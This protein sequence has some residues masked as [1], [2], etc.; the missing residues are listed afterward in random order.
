[1]NKDLGTR[2][3]LGRLLINK[4][5]AMN[6][7]IGLYLITVFFIPILHA[8][9]GVDL[10]APLF[11]W[12]GEWDG[13]VTRVEFMN[14][15]DEERPN[16]YALIRSVVK[17][18]ED[19][20][21]IIMTN[22][23]YVDGRFDVYVSTTFYSPEKQE[24]H[25]LGQYGTGVTT[26]P[27]KNLERNLTNYFN[28]SYTQVS[29]NTWI[30][31]DSLEGHGSFYEEEELVY[32]SWSLAVRVN[33]ENIVPLPNDYT[34]LGEHL[35]QTLKHIPKGAFAF[36]DQFISLDKLHEFSLMDT[37]SISP[38]ARKRLFNFTALRRLQSIQ[39]YEISEGLDW[40]EPVE[41]STIE[42]VN[43]EVSYKES[44][45]SFRLDLGMYSTDI[46]SYEVKLTAR[47]GE[48]ALHIVAHYVQLD[49][50]YHLMHIDEDID[51]K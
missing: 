1:M 4:C 47:A 16:E 15:E 33:T 45:T 38:R 20:F 10:E 9:S 7:L 8:Q 21:G 36:T 49:G 25:S 37:V 3:D 22:Y 41:W 11:R 5:S 39:Y 12:L 51:R 24:S 50:Q 31:S 46:P 26:Y 29:E 43:H 27:E 40:D 13:K 2:A 14:K 6:K 19:G 34:G 42:Y 35:F 23:Q 32:E 18:T 30:S 17:K 28:D 44:K 48:E